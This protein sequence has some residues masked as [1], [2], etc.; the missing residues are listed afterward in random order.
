MGTA[1]A[2]TGRGRP[3]KRYESVKARMQAVLMV[4]MGTFMIMPYL[5][6]IITA[7][8]TVSSKP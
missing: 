1:P 6:W 7:E 8:S 4:R 2:E 5:T 3:A